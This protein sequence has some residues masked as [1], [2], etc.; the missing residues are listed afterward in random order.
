MQY[1]ICKTGQNNMPSM[2]YAKQVS[3]RIPIILE[4][5]MLRL[6]IVFRIISSSELFFLT[7]HNWYFVIYSQ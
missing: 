2:K 6:R 4:F 5:L 3:H 7:L 1:H